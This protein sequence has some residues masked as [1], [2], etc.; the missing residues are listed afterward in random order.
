MHTE[1]LTSPDFPVDRLTAVGTT[2]LGPAALL[3]IAKASR[4]PGS[5]VRGV[6]LALLLLVDPI[7]SLLH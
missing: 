3:A 7:R 5:K 2:A 4:Q 1:T 6:A